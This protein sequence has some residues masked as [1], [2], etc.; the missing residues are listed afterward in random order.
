M[1]EWSSNICSHDEEV[2]KRSLDYYPDVLLPEEAM[3]VLMIG[4]NKIYE[5][6]KRNE[7]KAIKIGKQYRIPKKSLQEYIESCY[8]INADDS[9]NTTCSLKGV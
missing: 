5:L 4:R 2:E 1:T 6:L 8:A 9:D 3:K 7:L